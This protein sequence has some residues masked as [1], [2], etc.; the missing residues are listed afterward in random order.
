MSEPITIDPFDESELSGENGGMYTFQWLSSTEKRITEIPVDQL[1]SHQAELEATLAKIILA[2]EPYPAPGRALRV[3]VARC[4]TLLYTRAESRS[5][6]DTLQAFMKVTSDFK[7]VDKDVHKIAAFSCVGDLMAVFGAQYMSF[8]AEIVTVSLRTAR[9][10][11]QPLLRY[12]ALLTLQKSLTTAKR[13]VTDSSVKD[14]LK[15]MK[16]ALNDKCLP[17]QRVAANVLTALIT[18]PDSHVIE[19]NEVESILLLCIKSL[20]GADQITRQ[21]LAQ[22]V[23][24]ILSGTQIERAV[25]VPESAPKNKKSETDPAD[26]DVSSP[27]A[28][29][30]VTK[31]MLTPNEMF[32]LLSSQ[33]NKPNTARKTRIG[34][35]DFYVALLNKLGSTFVESNYSLIII[36]F[37]TEIVSNPRNNTNRYETLLIRTLV[38][39]VL[40]DLIGVRM[41]SEQG[42]IGAIRELA[43]L[44]LKRWPAMMPGQVAPSS[45][46]L[47]IV[48]REVAGLLQQLGNAPPPVQ[49]ALTEPLITLLAHP[50]HSTRVN[51]SWTLRCFCY[52]TPLRL[53]KAIITVIEMLQRDLASMLSPAAP[54]DVNPRTLGHAYGL[55]AL[56]S[57]IRERPLYVSYDVGAKV[58]DMAIQLLKRAGEHDVKIAGVEVEVSWMLIA[59]LMSLGPNFVRPHLPQLLVLWRNALPKPTSKDTANNAGRTI[60]EWMFLLHVRESA[61]GAIICFLQHNA[62]LITLDVGRRIS[63]VLS[64][65]LMFANNFMSV[66]VEEPPEMQMSGSKGL[67]LKAREAMLRRRVYQCFSILG[68]SSIAES[69]QTTLLQSVVSLFASPDGYTGS[70]VQAAIASSSGSFT[71]IW[72]SIDGYA[73]GVTFTEVANDAAVG[74]DGDSSTTTHDPLHRDTVEAVINELLRKPVLGGCEHDPLSLCQAQ[75]ATAEYRLVEQPP[76][77]TSVVDSA[78]ELFSLLLPLQDLS[79]TARTINQLLESVRSPKM[80]KNVGRKAAVSINASIALV[81]SLRNATT[82]HFQKARETFGSPQVTSLLSPFLKDLLVDGDHVLRAT[83]SESIG[84]LASLA[85][86]NFLTAQMKTLVDQVVSNRDPYARSGCALAFGAIYDY[87]GGL[88]AGPLLKTTVNVLMSLSNDPHP[89]VHFWALSALA[90]VINAASLAYAPFVSSTLGMLLKVYSM[91]SHEGGGASLSNANLSGDHPA[92][93]VVCQII[94]AVITVLGPDMQ[95]SVRTRA[96]VLN[97]V[98]NFF[99]EDDDSIRVEA[100]KCFQHFLMFAADHV[101]IP[102]L[103][104]SFRGYLSS[105]RRPLKVASINALYQLVQKDALAM[106]RLGGDRLVEN[107]FGMLDD[108][109][110]VEGV[111]NVISSWLQQTVIHNPSA[112]IDLCQ[113]IMSRTTASQQVADAASRQGARDDEGESLNLSGQDGNRGRLTSRWRTQLFAL[114]CLHQICTIVAKSGRREH[115]DVYFARKSEI[116]TGGLLVSRVPDLIK[117]AFTA[118]TAYVTEIRLEGL[119]VL[120]D[121]IQIFAQSPDPAFEDALL[122][123]QHQA[124]ITAALTPA[125]SAD[126]TPEILASAVHACAVFVGCGVVKDVSRMGRILRLLTVALEQSKDSGMVSLGEAGEL[127]PNA[128]AML[129]ISILSAWAQ[130]EVASYQQSYLLDVVNPYRATLASMWIAALRDYASIRID[131]EFLHDTSSAAVDSSY[132]NLGKEV[133]LPYY[134]SAWIIILQAV[135]TAMQAKDSFI[136]AAM[137]GREQVNGAAE[138]S[139]GARDEPTAFFFIVFGLVYEALAAAST[140]SMTNNSTRQAS[141]IT[142]LRTLKS[143]VRPEYAGKAILEPAIFDEFISVCYRMAMTESA[144]V[145]IHLIEVLT[146]FAAT[147][148]Q[149]SSVVT[150]L[151]GTSPRSHCLKICAHILRHSMPTGRGPTIQ[152]D[153]VDRVKMMLSAF[154]AFTTVASSSSGILREDIRAVAILLYSE[155]LKDDISET[156]LAG[157]TF[158]VLKTLLDL[159]VASDVDSADRY[160]KLVHGLLSSCLLHID[161]MR[162]RQGVPITKKVKNNLLAAVLILTV[163]PPKV[164]VSDAVIDHCCFLI[165]QKLLESSDASLTAAH[166]A[167]TLIAASA[168]GNIL[169]RHCVKQ[170]LPAL[171][172]YIAKMAPSVSDNSIPESHASAIGE[173]WKAFSAFFS[174]LGENERAR[175]LGVLLPTISLLLANSQN[176]TSPLL[177]QTVKHLLTYATSSPSAFK[178]AAAKLDPATRELL[179]QSVRKAVSGSATTTP[180]QS[181]VK[182]QISLRSF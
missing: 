160:Q 140:D 120:R 136:L 132:S 156:D 18:G 159:P 33:F 3:A 111:R 9:S 21:S 168:S 88:A 4:L 12:Q 180:A 80:E 161:E 109:S 23:G 19:K 123:E 55:A 94:D 175:L 31:S 138:P 166:C 70:S 178:E 122:L 163:I 108:D 38:G 60:A 154:S 39:I 14:I 99:L 32:N 146:I 130:L 57:I 66:N 74:V 64:N 100:I 105:P 90:R 104:N 103:V 85:G 148:D 27:V 131:S 1:K 52:S 44:Y 155:I 5:L 139:K 144:A 2:P 127:S 177:S 182:P 65:A 169:L 119:V 30:E 75:I 76:A 87:V 117:M 151:T 173:I 125:F 97:L 137:D 51:A 152:G 113:R 62:T 102:D 181:A 28:A 126:S 118:S 59:S 42:Q 15:Q 89:V 147:Q 167:K 110:S 26:D 6:F 157:P 54:S 149:D 50:S 40:R 35:F 16:S 22:L 84:R 143:L 61:L 63:S 10:S 37:M 95:E 83:S 78:I 170:L 142:A 79:S 114:Q 171:I 121:V 56:V 8:V 174:S 162:G 53:P 73:Y 13:A 45:A 91:N 41:L 115:L 96:L 25:P 176:T 141:V 43:N 48:L 7:A 134:T 86:T 172:E 153:L 24:H 106:S 81:L 107:L 135:A 67:S 36:H 150:S 179:E 112:W 11:N 101:S 98:H 77:F 69:T 58:L 47:V 72:Q 71:S 20:E 165:S 29:A 68:F 46:V 82:N 49:D 128:S 133:L 116:P 92:Y 164:K 34:I 129:R 93:P 124:P 158:P 17:V 145:E